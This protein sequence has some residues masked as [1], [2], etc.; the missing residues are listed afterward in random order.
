MKTNTFVLRCPH[1]GEPIR[2]CIP[3]VK[4]PIVGSISGGAYDH[5]IPWNYQWNGVCENYG[6]ILILKWRRTLKKRVFL[7]KHQ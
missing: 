2:K 4:W 3:N 1:C 7:V 6:T 5:K